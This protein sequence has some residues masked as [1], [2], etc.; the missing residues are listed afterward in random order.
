MGIFGSI[1][2][3]FT[4]AKNQKKR[5]ENGR[6]TAQILYMFKNSTISVGVCASNLSFLI[7]ENLTLS[8]LPNLT[9]T[10]F[11]RLSIR[12]GMWILLSFFVSKYKYYQLSDVGS[13]L[14]FY[15]K[16]RK[17]YF[18][19]YS[20]I[21]SDTQDDDRLQMRM[22]DKI[23]DLEKDRVYLFDSEDKITDNGVI[24]VKFNRDIQSY[25]YEDM[26]FNL[27][28]HDTRYLTEYIELIVDKIDYHVKPV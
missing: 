16:H 4:E 13:F 8:A 17:D 10:Q 3:G 27:D 23:E 1:K 12:L 9:N 22:Y 5:D 7:T 2:R 26:G 11:N 18:N 21:S 15:K 19:N 24:E 28:A 6:K 14:D 25:V 20:S